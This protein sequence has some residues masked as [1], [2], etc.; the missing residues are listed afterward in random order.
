MSWT[1]VHT[2]WSSGFGGQEHRILIESRE[3]TRRGHRVLVACP[4]D[5]ALGPKARDAG[6][7]VTEIP[8]RAALDPA[9]VASLARLFRREGATVVNTHSGKDSWVGSMAAKIAGVP[10]LLRT[11]HISLPVRRT[12]YN[13][14][15]RWPDGY[16][17]TGEPIREHLIRQG[18]P[19]DRVVSIPTGVDVDRFSPSVSGEAVR[20]E[21][22]IPPGQRVVSVIGVLRSW[23]RIDLFVEIAEILAREEPA[24]RFLVVGEGPQEK[25][26]RRKIDELGVGGRVLLLGHRDDVPEILAAS[27]AMVMTSMKE[28]LPQVVLQ[29][30]AMERP[31]V[32]S[33]VGAI[34]EAVTHGETGLLCPPGEAGGFVAAI[35]SL[36]HDPAL[37]RRLGAAGRRRILERHSATAMGE[38]TEAFY[39]HLA[40][41]KGIVPG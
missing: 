27:D 20:R 1:I 9:A 2:E 25:N 37:G 33:P 19:A 24:L 3:M 28:G 4:P 29:A 12:F 16:I 36:L 18:I 5:A 22:G 17:T 11:R 7:P 41:A 6:I 38:M 30:L 8:I 35:R 32:A 10:L 26:I 21:L 39:R 14:I 40:S 31:V 23:K 15:W 13:A 34:P